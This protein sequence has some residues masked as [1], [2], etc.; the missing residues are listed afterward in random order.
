MRVNQA[1]NG[2]QVSF[3]VCL[4]CF[5]DLVT[6]GE[7]NEMGRSQRAP[8]TNGQ[9]VKS[10]GS[11][12]APHTLPAPPRVTTPLLNLYGR[13]LTASAAHSGLAQA[14]SRPRE[15][16]RI[17]TILTRHQKS[18]P[19]LIGEPGVGKTTIVEGLAFALTQGTV[20]PRLSGKRIVSLNLASLVAGTTYRGQLEQRVDSLLAEL[21]KHPEVILFID[22]LYTVIGRDTGSGAVGELLKPALARDELHCIGA[23]TIE[24]YR[25]SFEMDSMLKRCFQ[26][27][28]IAEPSTEETMTILQEMRPTYEEHHGVQ[29]TQEALEA[30]IKLSARYIPERF[31][32]DKAIDILDEAGA[33]MHMQVSREEVVSL[34]ITP[35]HIAQV[36]ENWTGIPVGQV[37]ENERQNLRHLEETLNKRVIGQDEAINVVARAIRRARA[38]LNDPQRPIASFLFLG[39]TGVGKTELAKALA[40]TLL[41]SE[42]RMI[43]LDMSE[44]MEEHSVARLFG[45]PP[46]YAGYQE[47]GQLTEL[48]HS[49]PYSIILCDE[50]EKAHPKVLN[51]LLQVLDDG[52]L[53][54]GRGRTIDFKNT[55]IIMT[56]N[57]GAAAFQHARGIG[58][59][60]RRTTD[61]EEH[62]ISPRILH[63]LKQAFRPEFL[64]RI[65]QIVAFRRLGKND[66]YRIVNL[67]MGQVCTRLDEQGITLVITNQVRDFLLHVGYDEEYGVRPLRRAIQ[68]FVDD[69]LADAILNGDIIAGQTITF[70]VQ[71][72]EL[73]ITVLDAL[74]SA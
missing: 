41:G 62:I 2:N 50:I 63:E 4:L 65:D 54:D 61:V 43:R 66:L 23:T 64:N 44:Y 45:S 3:C 36:V 35:Q 5:N 52:R 9:H 15:L 33:T 22:E 14:P 55:V 17:L 53:T 31:L 16:Q 51:T 56:S 32:P 25:K 60:D 70:T 47:G 42:Q 46:G 69:Q 20:P 28:L 26:P 10:P 12:P 38:G 48:V 6:K 67:L 40:T 73:A 74:K 7:I 71:D 24:E 57:V 37:L 11:A 27:V 1:K 21:R 68:H 29:I 18:N 58:F 8:K 59:I 19:L 34:V 30:A 72:G 39:S 13:D 49:Q